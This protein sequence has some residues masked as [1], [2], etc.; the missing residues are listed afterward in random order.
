MKV[1]RPERAGVR[2]RRDRGHGPVLRGRLLPARCAFSSS[3]CCFTHGQS[4]FHGLMGKM[5]QETVPTSVFLTRPDGGGGRFQNDPGQS[6]LLAAK[7][8]TF[9]PLHR[10]P[11]SPVFLDFLSRA[12]PIRA[13]QPER[14]HA[15]APRRGAGQ[16][17]DRRATVTAT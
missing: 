17:G 16:P 11:P 4:R 8:P 10:A 12:P 14:G 15:P 5:R 1:N 3:N 2:Q 13:Q 7:V 9:V 6:F